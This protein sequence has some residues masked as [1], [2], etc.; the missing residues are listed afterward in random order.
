VFTEL[1]P[2]NALIKSVTLI[3]N[4]DKRIRCEDS[5]SHLSENT[6]EWKAVMNVAIFKPN[7]R[8]AGEL[9]IS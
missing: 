8:V 3:L 4:R 1:L 7:K 2:G 6:V 5:K 9:S